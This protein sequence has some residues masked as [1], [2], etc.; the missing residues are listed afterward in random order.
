M[1]RLTETLRALTAVETTSDLDASPRRGRRFGR[2]WVVGVIA[3][4]L[5]LTT[6]GVAVASAHKTIDLDVDGEVRTVSTFAGSVPGLLRQEGVTLGEH[7]TVSVNGRLH[8]GATIVVRHAKLLHIAS[9][10]TVTEVWSTALSAEEA[11]APLS[12]DAALLVSRA[13]SDGRPVFPLDLAKEGP[14]RVVAD[15]TTTPLDSGDVSVAQALVSAEV[16]LGALDELQVVSGSEGVHVVV[17]RV[18][19][20]QVTTTEEIPFTSSTTNDANRTVGTRVVVTAGVPGVRTVVATVTTADGVERE[21]V[22]LSDEITAEPVHEVVAVGTKPKPQPAPAARPATGGD[23]PASTGRSSAGLNWAA[24]AACESGGNPTIVSKS[25]KYHG[26]Y[27][28]SVATWQ[29]VGGTGLPSQASAAEQTMRA[30]M[31]YERSGA[32]QWPHCGPR[33][34]R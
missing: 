12:E 5:V 18:V 16:E 3:G 32:G 4:A 26:L 15:G 19:V 25:G 24:L 29:S 23:V 2:P 20:E 7:D 31:L 27:Q 30:Q 14:A 1:Q 8:D 9:G 13:S 6:G 28:F 33:L 21:R 10:D 34:F 22:V 11:L 17:T